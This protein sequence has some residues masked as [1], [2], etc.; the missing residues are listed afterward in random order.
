MGVLSRCLQGIRLYVIS[1]RSL[2]FTVNKCNIHLFSDVLISVLSAVSSPG[3]TTS[4]SNSSLRPSTS[5]KRMPIIAYIYSWVTRKPLNIMLRHFAYIF[6]FQNLQLLAMEWDLSKA[7]YE[8]YSSPVRYQG[9]APCWLQ[10]LPVFR[11]LVHAFLC[12][13]DWYVPTLYLAKYHRGAWRNYDG[14]FIICI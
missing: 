12:S 6:S 2:E 5:T 3:I 10:G 1:I 9:H 14:W 8:F 7:A 11:G 4:S 13:E